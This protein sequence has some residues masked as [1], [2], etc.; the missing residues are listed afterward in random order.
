M[1]IWFVYAKNDFTVLPLKY[2]KP[3]LKR[4]DRIGAG[5]IT[6]SEF[7]DVHDT[8]GSFNKNGRP[9]QYFGHFSWIYFLNNECI[10]GDLSIWEWM[11]HLGTGL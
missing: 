3:L 11:S 7:A 1:P 10:D 9:Y 4:F 8:S 2:E 5:N 6:V